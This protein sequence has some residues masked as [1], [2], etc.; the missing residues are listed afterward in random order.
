MACTSAEHQVTRTV[1]ATCA[2]KAASRQRQP[3][4][5]RARRATGAHSY[6]PPLALRREMSFSTAR[7]VP[8]SIF[9]FWF[10]FSISSVVSAMWLL[11]RRG[12]QRSAAPGN[13]TESPRKQT[14]ARNLRGTRTHGTTLQRPETCYLPPD[15]CTQ[16][17][18]STTS[19]ATQQTGGVAVKT[20]WGATEGEERSQQSARHM[21]H[22]RR[23]A[24]TSPAPRGPRRSRSATGCTGSASCRGAARCGG[25]RAARR[26]RCARWGAA[27]PRPTSAPARPSGP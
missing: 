16:P 24:R 25:T 21:E 19:Q 22:E 15:T 10:I 3:R 1:V 11:Q 23:A 8:S 17:E 13:S 18:V 12:A 26:T 14:P 4:K 27:R 9:S 20:E 7:F 2:H 6:P 5:Q